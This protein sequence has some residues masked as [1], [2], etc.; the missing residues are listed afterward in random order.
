M[1]VALLVLVIFL[2]GCVQVSTV[3]LTTD[4]VQITAQADSTCGARGAE[5]VALHQASVETIKRGFDRFLIVDSKATSVTQQVGQTPIRALFTPHI[6]SVYGGQ[7]IVDETHNQV[8]TVK[9]FHEGDPAGNKALWARELLGKNWKELVAKE[10][11]ITCV[12]P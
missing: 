5:Q 2:T 10:T 3:P 4:V 7:P 11:P 8:F 12:K 6:V 1:R 9:M